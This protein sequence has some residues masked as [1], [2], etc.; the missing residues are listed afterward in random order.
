MKKET[1]VKAKQSFINAGY[2]PA[3]VAAATKRMSMT[4]SPIAQQVAP[5]RNSTSPQ[6]TKPLQA[7]SSTEKPKGISK[8]F[9]IILISLSVVVLIGVALLGIFWD[10]VF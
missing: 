1:L 10:K 7:D 8:T 5:P 3:E 6:A 2:K 4:S 9:K